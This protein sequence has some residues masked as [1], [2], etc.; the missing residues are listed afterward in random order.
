VLKAHKL[1]CDGPYSREPM[2]A[3]LSNESQPMYRQFVRKKTINWPSSVFVSLSAINLFSQDERQKATFGVEYINKGLPP[4][5]L[6]T[7]DTDQVML[8]MIEL[9]K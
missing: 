7:Q 9:D 3:H 1:R 2:A 4:K 5:L 8:Q 6:A